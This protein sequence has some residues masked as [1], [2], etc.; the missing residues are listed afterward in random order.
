MRSRLKCCGICFQQ[1][2][3]KGQK[4]QNVLEMVLRTTPPG[5]PEAVLDAV[6]KYGWNSEFLMNI[7]DR[8][9]AILD[10]ALQKCQPQVSTHNSNSCWLLDNALSS[11][12]LQVTKPENMCNSH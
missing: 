8:K 1:P 5:N 3:Y 2:E 6:D 9:G 12:P 10:K 7:G 4:E 11:A